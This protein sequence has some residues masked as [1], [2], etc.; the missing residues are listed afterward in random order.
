[1]EADISESSLPVYKALA[2]PVRL[3]I[4]QKLSSHKMSVYALSIALELSSTII[5]QHL[6]KLEAAGIVKF[7]RSGHNK[8][9]R[10]TVDQ[11][12]VQFPQ[13]IYPEF[14]SYTTDVPVGHFTNFSVK[15]SCGLAG[16]TDYIGKVDNPAYFMDPD[17][18]SAGMI[19]WCNG[20]VEYQFPNYLTKKNNI[21]MLDL[22]MELGSEFPFSNNVWPSDITFYINGTEI[23]TW[24]APGDFSDTRGK[25]T[26]EWV[27]DNVNQYGILKTLRLTHE[28]SF[29]DGQPFTDVTLSD[30]TTD[31][32]TFSVRYGIKKTAKNN[33][34]CT[35]FGKGFGNY[36]QDIEM[37]LFYS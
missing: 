11:I 34:G 7:E 12:N 20:F 14:E 29:L 2:S 16:K 5:L 6:N 32:E 17:R 28:G 23:G 1:M 4:I 33:G 13:Q 31:K 24:T 21:E 25:Y 9:A 30:I 3:K 35:I 27:P 10:L 37:K 19:W 36:N 26:P 8:V 22:T 18:I 15:P